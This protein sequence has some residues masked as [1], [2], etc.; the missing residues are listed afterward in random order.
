V[1]IPNL[2]LLTYIDKSLEL[3]DRVAPYG[4]RDD[5]KWRS[6]R[7]TRR[8]THYLDEGMLYWLP[9][10]SMMRESERALIAVIQVM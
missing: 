8:D 10:W 5:K 6:K 9:R 4:A 7:Q 3:G 2:W 1:A